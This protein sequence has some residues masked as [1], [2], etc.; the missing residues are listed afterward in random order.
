MHQ[1][2]FSTRLLPLLICG[3]FVA[4]DALA[5]TVAYWRH[6]DGPLG[7]D[8]D[9]ND[10]NAVWDY[11]GNFNPMRTFDGTTGATFVDT[12]APIPLRSGLTNSLALDFDRD[13]D[14]TG[15]DKSD[16]N[17]TELRFIESQLFSEIT[18]E[19]AFNLETTDGF[20]NMFG[21]D[22]KPIDTVNI[23]PIQ[24]KVRGDSFPN[25]IDH[26]LQ[27]EWI[28]G[29]GDEIS[30]AS[31]FSIQAGT[32]YHVAFTLT[33]DT[34]RL[35]IATNTDDYVLVAEITGEDFAAPGGE[36]IYDSI[37]T[38]DIGRGF[39]NGNL[40]D[41]ADGI[42]DEVR[43]DDTALDPSNFLFDRPVGVAADDDM[44]GVPN[45]A[46]ACPDT[47]LG[48]L[49]DEDGRPIGDLNQDCYN[50]MIDF[51]LYQQGFSG[52]APS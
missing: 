11:T 48:V 40:V 12:V 9:P 27:I 29:D 42:I 46:D 2:R 47:P 6:D 37:G 44:D 22:G 34:A 10:P 50:D 30:L 41:W 16:D 24:C 18:I 52:P 33:S 39:Y 3:A 19:W 25:G 1:Q 7:T 14:G 21:K 36:V 4:T 45:Y 20:A 49:V 28:D 31:G 43:I 17:Y 51:G 23:A 8:V 13:E 35:Y 26:Q 15:P 5:G 32:W 38:I